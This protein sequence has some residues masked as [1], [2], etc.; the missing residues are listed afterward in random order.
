[1]DT[2]GEKIEK[3]DVKTLSYE[4]GTL[5]SFHGKSE[6]GHRMRTDRDGSISPKRKRSCET[7]FCIQNEKELVALISNNK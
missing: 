6:A 2:T 7:K 5:C 4:P 3:L 1:M